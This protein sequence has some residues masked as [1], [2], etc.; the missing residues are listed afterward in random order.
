MRI[1]VWVYMSFCAVEMIRSQD[2]QMKMKRPSLLFKLFEDFKIECVN[3][4][5][6]C[7]C[8][9]A[10]KILHIFLICS[11]NVYIRI[12]LILI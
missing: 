6:T 4:Y 12:T 10:T 8:I 11:S 1:T 5:D 2:M 3:G 9:I 7:L